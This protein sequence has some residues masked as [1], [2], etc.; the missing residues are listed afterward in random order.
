MSITK[1]RFLLQWVPSYQKVTKDIVDICNQNPDKMVDFRPYMILNPYT[2][3]TTDT[4]EKAV[5]IF[6]SQHLR[7]LPVV[8]PGTGEIRGMITR[9]DLFRF[10]DL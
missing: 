9:K 3:S 10:M 7:H 2:V 8:H 6:R 5:N 4:L 1:G